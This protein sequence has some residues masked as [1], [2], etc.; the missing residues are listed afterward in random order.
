M[1]ENDVGIKSASR[2]EIRKLSELLR[3]YNKNV[4]HDRFDED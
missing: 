3:D 4:V 2:N 1:P